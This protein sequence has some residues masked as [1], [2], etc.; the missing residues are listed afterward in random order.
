[1]I[2]DSAS[3]TT[4][5]YTFE[6]DEKS[7][8]I[9][10]SLDKPFALL[11]NAGTLGVKGASVFFTTLV[12]A[13]VLNIILLIWALIASMTDSFK[14]GLTSLG[15]V[16]LAGI[17][18]TVVL[19]Q[20]AYSYVFINV[21]NS[22][23]TSITSLVKK[24]CAAVIDK[25]AE[26]LHKR[27]ITSSLA[28]NSVNVYAIFNE[29]LEML[30]PYARKGLWFIIKRIPFIK[31]LDHEITAVVLSGN[32][33]EA[34][35]MLYNKTNDFIN[36]RIF[37]ANTTTTIWLIFVLNIAVQLLFILLNL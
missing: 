7:L 30:S 23:Y 2:K 21:L 20:K 12:T 22:I 19:V 13:V 26:E 32:K 1:M 17:I 9:V 14:T 37:G 27:K 24:L 34:T 29:K 35:N 6:M 8:K 15:L 36:D 3:G 16:L 33:A 18:F 4:S 31:L 10:N 25:I 5:A 28:T 11:K